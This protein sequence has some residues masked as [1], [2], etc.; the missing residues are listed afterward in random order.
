MAAFPSTPRGRFLPVGAVAVPRS[1]PLAAARP[2]PASPSA[3]YRF[4][5]WYDGER[6]SAGTSRS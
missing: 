5:Q 1:A 6:F 3:Q 4:P 2:S